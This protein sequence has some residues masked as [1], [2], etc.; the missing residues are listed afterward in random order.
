MF[1]FI[2]IKEYENLSNEELVEENKLL[3]SKRS[4]W[5]RKYK[6][7][8]KVRKEQELPYYKKLR[9]EF[10]KYRYEKNNE[11]NHLKSCIK[12]TKSKFDTQEQ[13]IE[14]LVVTYKVNK[15]EVVPNILSH[16][17]YKQ[18]EQELEQM[19]QRVQEIEAR[20]ERYNNEIL[21]KKGFKL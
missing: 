4:F 15:L 7:I 1:K 12:N 13:I 11:I 9:E 20:N 8:Q 19:K 18:M 17:T 10:D 5:Q 3:E 14:Y 21:K 16:K 6:H 2:K